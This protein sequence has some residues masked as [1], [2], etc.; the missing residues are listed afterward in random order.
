MGISEAVANITDMTT[1]IAA[2]T[3]EQTAVAEEISRNISTI[4]HLAD[5]TSEQ[6]QNSALLSEELTRTAGTQYSL[7]ERFN[8]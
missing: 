7:V 1:Q 4:A 6:A 5:Q 8:R 2:A 3:E